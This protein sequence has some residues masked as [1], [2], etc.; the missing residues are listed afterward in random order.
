MKRDIR[1]SRSELLSGSILNNKDQTTSPV[2][3]GGAIASIA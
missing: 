2:L 1:A 3:H